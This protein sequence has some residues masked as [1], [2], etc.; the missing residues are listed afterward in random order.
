MDSPTQTSG[1]WLTAKSSLY[2]TRH[3]QFTNIQHT[4]GLGMGA[5]LL[6]FITVPS[7]PAH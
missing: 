6:I 4:K 2:G 1:Q 5:A 7:S 3:G